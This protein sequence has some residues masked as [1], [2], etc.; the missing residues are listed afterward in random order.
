[1]DPAGEKRSEGPQKAQRA[2]KSPGPDISIYGYFDYRR[3]LADYYLYRK[4]LNRRFSY[5]GFALRAG[6]NS[7]GLYLLIVQGKQNLT[8][9]YLPKFAMAMELG[10]VETEYFRL[11]VDFT[12]AR[13]AAA[14]QAALDRMADLMPDGTKELRKEQ[15]EYYRNW[16]N[17]AVREA[18]AV[19]EVKDSYAELA[20]FIHP[21]LTA[22]Q[23]KGSIRLLAALGL[24]KKQAKGVWKATNA[25]IAST[26]DLGPLPVR[27]FQGIMMDLAKRALDDIPKESRNISCSTFSASPQGL[28]R[29]NLKVA[30][31]LRDIEDIVRS[32]EK[33]DCIFQ[34]NLQLFPLSRR[35]L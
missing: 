10:P 15:T 18:L 11:M 13:T 3:Y 19:L 28:E 26:P 6:Y 32:D 8:P 31:L 23:A 5:R 12:H 16:H 25:V 35:R 9:A 17:V 27:Q 2:G 21:P 30:G 34:L 24:I 4:S 14:K 22:A 33:E 20:A 1:M 29:I 7:S